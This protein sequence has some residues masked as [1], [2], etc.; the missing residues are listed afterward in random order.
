MMVKEMFEIMREFCSMTS[1]TV[2][3]NGRDGDCEK[4]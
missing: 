4:N 2:P 3:N 1:I